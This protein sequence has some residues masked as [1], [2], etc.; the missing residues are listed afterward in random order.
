MSFLGAGAPAHAHSD[1]YEASPPPGATV[2]PGTRIISLMFGQLQEGSK[3]KI[4]LYGPDGKP[5]PVG[6]PVL[7]LRSTV[8]AAVER[9]PVGVNTIIYEVRAAD[10]D[11]Q[12]NR[13]QF[14]VAP[15]AE[16]PVVPSAC[17][18][19]R[20]PGPSAPKNQAGGFLDQ[21]GTAVA[22]GSAAGIAAVGALGVFVMRAKRRSASLAA[23][24]GTA[25]TD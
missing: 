2:G 4:A 25:G 10:S 12:T 3:P 24:G 17:S 16:V 15:N 13:F 9:L 11:T 1:L 21:H 6:E 19:Q 22:A 7:V 8:C 18:G 14:E 20:L 5:V 23:K